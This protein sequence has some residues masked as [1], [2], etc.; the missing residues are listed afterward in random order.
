MNARARLWQRLGVCLV[1]AGAVTAWS[2]QVT[3]AQTPTADFDTLFTVGISAQRAGDFAAAR[4][5]YV[6]AL[7]LKPEHIEALFRLGLVQAFL[8]DYI[9]ALETLSQAHALAPNDMDIR[10]AMARV[11]SWSGQLGQALSQIR[12]I[13]EDAPGLSEAW[14]LLGRVSL[15]QSDFDAAQTAFDEALRLSPTSPEAKQGLDDTTAAR[16]AQVATVVQA[17]PDFIWRLDTGYEQSQ[18][19]RST[20]KNW[21][22]GYIQVA[23]DIG[24]NTTVHLRTEESHRFGASDTYLR[25]GVHY[26]F[27]PSLQA[28][29]QIGVT[30]NADFLPRRTTKAG[31]TVQVYRGGHDYLIGT[32]LL[33]LD[34]QNREYATGDIRNVDP[35]LQLYV[36]NGRGW[37][38]GRWINSFDIAAGKRLAGWSGRADWY[39]IDQVR[40]FAGMAVSP[41]TDSGDTVETTS[42]FGGINVD[43]TPQWSANLAYTKDDREESYIRHVLTFGLSHKF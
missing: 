37:L 23:R 28:Y 5:A 12:A 26:R 16:A 1:L 42:H 7:S 38:T 2:V 34:L 43:V 30:P 11:H 15:Y 4:D 9:T 20:N 41:E 32:T 8:K 19:S 21:N 33:S 35:G 40:I 6:R 18:F 39:L 29:A 36:L 3:R 13:L 10:L 31:G 22:E 27:S 14:I 24:A 25:T 17:T